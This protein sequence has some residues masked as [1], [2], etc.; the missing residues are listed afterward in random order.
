VTNLPTR[1]AVLGSPIGHSKSPLL[2]AAA[3]RVLGLDWVYDRAELSGS[4][5]EG[6]ITGCD[7]SWRGLSLTMPLKRDI[8]PLLDTVDPLVT[9]T[10]AANT[11]LFEAGE[12]GVTERTL[13]GFNTDVYG[14]TQALREAGV[15]ELNLVHLLGAGATAASVLVAIVE[16]GARRVEVFARTPERAAPLVALGEALG[17]EIVVRPLGM[18]DGSGVVPDL[19]ASTLPGDARIDHEFTEPVRAGA[20][21]FDVAYAPWPSALAVRW[22]GT[23]VSGLEMLLH[24]AVAQVRIFVGGSP[25]EPLPD[26]A[27]VLAAMRSAV[28]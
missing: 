14:V 6:F 12:D 5:L 2:H 3:Y 21:L 18:R 8:L 27:S 25:L 19:V 9:L 24:Q 26:E 20:V 11:V 1:L 23:V 15:G 7:T 4:E 22:Q 17:V 10:G 16:L 28:A 13:H